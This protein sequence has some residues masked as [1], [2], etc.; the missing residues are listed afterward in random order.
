MIEDVEVP[1]GWRRVR[2]GEVL[3]VISQKNK[4]VKTTEYQNIGLYPIVDQSEKK[5]SGFYDN[6]KKVITADLPI[7]IFG[8]HTRIVKYID[9]PFI[10]GADGTQ[11]LKPLEKVDIK[12]FYYLIVKA[13]E[14][15]G[16]Y[17][18][19]RH[20][21]YLKEHYILFP[22]SLSEQHKIAEILDTVD[23]A[24]ERTDTIIE[25]YKQIKQ[26]L[27]QDLLLRDEKKHGFKD[28][29]LGR[30]PEEWMVVEFKDIC[31]V[32]QGLQIAIANRFKEP[33]HKRYIYITILY[34]NSNDKEKDAEY[35]Q[36]PPRSVICRKNDILMTR[37]G[38]TGMV[39]T[40]VDGV[41]HNNFFL[42]DYDK[43]EV[44]KMYLFYYLNI[45]WIQEQIR[46]L[47]GT[48][49]IPDLNHNDFYSLK[50]LKPPLPEQHRIA[51]IL[52]Q[53]AQTI[54][55]EQKCKQK[56]ESIKQGIMEDLLTGKVRVNHLI[57]E[58]M[59]NVQTA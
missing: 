35:I 15:I 16:N 17:G 24:I 21:K 42:V 5:I 36:N 34:L 23:N 37:T 46:A 52:S 33:G 19:D 51:S 3:F 29:P 38:N 20:L 26:G 45:H 18:Y 54:E 27:M 8:D 4:Q 40:D 22:S 30:I 58:G 13:S 56:L 25:K 12:F 14:Q 2:L 55:K 47:A 28:S 1:E 31:K 48:T 7:V 11:I 6:T 50:F 32:R 44:D 57:E 53:M 43:K 59:K 41:F 49:T 39:I 9:F 10:P